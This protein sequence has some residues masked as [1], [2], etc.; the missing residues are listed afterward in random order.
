M[1]IALCQINPRVAD[2]SGNTAQI[3]AEI[4]AYQNECDLIV[5][6]ELA[7]PGY[8]PT[9]Q[10]Y[11]PDFQEK[12]R[13]ANEEVIE[14]TRQG[15][16]T[17]VWGTMI[18]ANIECQARPANGL[19]VAKAGAVIAEGRK[20]YLPTYSVYDELRFFAPN[21]G[22]LCLFD[23]M[24]V[25]IGTTICE[26]FWR[27]D[28][29]HDF[30]CYGSDL[31]M[32]LKEAGAELLLNLSA[33]PYHRSKVSERQDVVRGVSV[34]SELPMLYV[35][36]V[37]GNDDII[38][39]GRSLAWDAQGQ[40][41][42]RAKAYKPDTLK[43]T[44]SDG[45]LKAA[46]KLEQ[47]EL[48]DASF[49]DVAEAL[50]LGLKDFC[51]KCGITKVVLGLSGGIDS[52]VTASLACYALGAENVIGVAMPSEISSQESH[53]DAR[54]MAEALG[55]DFKTIPIGETLSSICSI[56]E[57]TTGSAPQ[58]LEHENLQPRI[59][60]T[61]LM[62]LANREKALVLATG[63]KAEMAVGYCTMYGDMVGGLAVLGDLL[64]LEVYEVGRALDRLWGAQMIPERVY[65]KAPTAELRPD[66]QDEDSL[67]AY[68]K[69]DLF[70]E[71]YL[72]NKMTPTAAA[73]EGLD[74]ARWA[75]VIESM[76]FKRQ[77]APPVLRVS[78]FAFQ[79]ERQTMVAKG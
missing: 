45:S 63:N 46:E 68:D 14:A 36:L 75:R 53:D 10:V 3:L 8:P 51:R 35:N 37:G 72:R 50:T 77:Q 33:S 18:P 60:G 17:V 66:Q 76:D 47:P 23:V 59:R 73:P 2:V 38:F 6:P 9:D 55:L 13:S 11:R 65:T 52:A 28:D 74:G 40:E 5:F 71:N 54:I 30:R 20:S 79:R 62:A 41:L 26:D 19:L 21:S 78:D 25:R 16:A 42:C 61:L 22:E 44:W 4:R 69:L 24:G 27:V 56:L 67:P 57:T 58:G 49:E 1:Q 7:L 29:P 43:L 32:E 39:D 64:K 34:K 48:E 70:I 12:V 31:G 15:K